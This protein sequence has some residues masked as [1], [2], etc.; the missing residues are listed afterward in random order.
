M[1]TS[2]SEF[3]KTCINR[4]ITGSSTYL[5]IE[6]GVHYLYY[7]KRKMFALEASNHVSYQF[8]YCCCS[9]KFNKCGCRVIKYENSGIWNKYVKLIKVFTIDSI[10]NQTEIISQ[11]EIE[12]LNNHIYSPLQLN[13]WYKF[14]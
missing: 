13:I 6:R 5:L 3:L 7:M 9:N 8:D 4:L 14:L 10:F 1:I 11:Q 2:T 12:L